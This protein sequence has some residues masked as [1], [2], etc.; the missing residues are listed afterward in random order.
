MVT[1]ILTLEEMQQRYDGEWLL[2]ACT[3]MDKQ[4]RVSFGAF[5]RAG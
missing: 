4:L 2:I 5:G 1:N 3:E